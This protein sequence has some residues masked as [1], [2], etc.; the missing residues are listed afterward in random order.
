MNRLS[1]GSINQNNHFLL[2]SIKMFSKYYIEMYIEPL[3]AGKGEAAAQGGAGKHW[4]NCA[5]SDWAWKVF[6][7][8]GKEMEAKPFYLKKKFN[9]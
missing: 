3:K 5:L 7:I 1:I 6:N 8:R 4:I 9:I 2:Y